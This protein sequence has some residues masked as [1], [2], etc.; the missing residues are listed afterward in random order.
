M[1]QSQD[2]LIQNTPLPVDG[3][4]VTQ[5]VS[6]TVTV[7]QA[8]GTNLHTVIDSGTVTTSPVVSNTATVTQITSTGVNQT[9][10]AANVSRKKLY[11]FF[12]SGVWYVK[13]GATASTTSFT[14]QITA[15]NTTFSD[16]TWTG[17][18]DAICTTSNKLV[19]ITEL[20]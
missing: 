19:N 6:G 17:Q 8:T 9:L 7:T 4:G 15:S 16:M 2:V 10:L 13:F 20:V 11:L 14:I 5:P 1:I 3:S 12:Q 18:V